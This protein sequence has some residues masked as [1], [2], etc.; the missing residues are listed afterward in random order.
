LHIDPAP[1]GYDARPMNPSE[2]SELLLAADSRERWVDGIAAYFSAYPLCYGHGTERA[3]DEAWWLVWQLSGTPADL[4]ALPPDDTLVTRLVAIARRRVEE[5]LPLGYLLGVAWFGGLEFRVTPDVLIPRS[6]MAEILEQGFSP[7]LELAE[8]DRILDVGTGSGCIAIAA[9]VHNPGIHVDATEI[10]PAALTVA[11]ENLARHGV[12]DRVRLIEADLFPR[13]ATRYRVIMS[14]PPYVPSA[15]VAVLPPE[16]RHEPGS[17][18]DGGVDGLDPA[19]R[20]L[21]GAGSR[22][23]DDGVLIVEVGG[24]AAAL[25]AAYPKIPWTWLEFERGGDGV[26]LLSADELKNGWR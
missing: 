8:G 13:G 24:S 1:N 17:A 23:T 21:A 6:P 12:G 26:F 4:A 3:E 19:R 18:L 10:S 5:R 2:L 9:A 22:L 16:Y 20:L 25:E 15:E 14:N 11:R 7:W